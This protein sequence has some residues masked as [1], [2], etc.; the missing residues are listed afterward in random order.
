MQSYFD[1]IDAAQRHA[2]AEA[3]KKKSTADARRRLDAV[4]I[5]SLSLY[6]LLCNGE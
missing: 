1:S 4:V 6:H 3:A 2:S 5:R